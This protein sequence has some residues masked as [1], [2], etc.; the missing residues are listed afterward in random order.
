MLV[1]S[2]GHIVDGPEIFHLSYTFSTTT[3][4]LTLVTS[5]SNRIKEVVDPGT[6][7]EEYAR[8]L[9]KNI[10]GKDISSTARTWER[11]FGK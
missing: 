2:I 8:R 7:V 1:R 3:R 6:S 11:S 9:V 4:I 5:K 10:Y